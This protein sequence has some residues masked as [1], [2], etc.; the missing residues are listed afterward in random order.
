MAV[1]AKQWT[2]E[3]LDKQIL[4]DP[5]FHK[6][7][8][9]QQEQFALEVYKSAGY[10]PKPS[11]ESPPPQY[12][13]QKKA[14][15]PPNE[16]DTFLKQA[17]LPT[18]GAAGGNI[19]GTA[20]G[21]P[22]G[23]MIGEAAGSG[24]GEYANQKLG[25]SPES[26]LSIGLSTITPP[27][28]R[29]GAAALQHSPRLLPGASAALQEQAAQEARA[30]PSKAISVPTPSSELFSKLQ[31]MEKSHTVKVPF[32]RTLKAVKQLKA[33]ELGS[34]KGTQDVP[35]IQRLSDMEE[36]LQSGGLTFDEFDKTI[37]NLGRKISST[38]DATLKGSF[39]TIYRSLLEDVER[40]PAPAGV[41]L[42]L[43]RQA[44]KMYRK[45]MARTEF[46]NVIESQGIRKTGEF[47]D[48]VNPNAIA[49]WMKS[50]KQDYW[51]KSLDPGEYQQIESTLKDWATIPKNPVQRGQ[52]IG[53]G[54]KI[55]MVGAG[56]AIGGYAGGNMGAAFGMLAADKGSEYIA[57]ALTSTT[58]RNVLIKILRA[59]GGRFGQ[60]QAGLLGAFLAGGFGDVVAGSAGETPEAMQAPSRFVPKGLGERPRP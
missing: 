60:E 29:A 17:P 9:P 45:E 35:L 1:L 19:L 46:A 47:L 36:G 11:I 26:K 49:N 23:G 32:A 57:Q 15:A 3:E 41:P 28:F 58:G 2:V 51:R 14:A 44:R 10:E 5:D 8:P 59:S 22:V 31:P 4:A 33:E 18:L 43:W 48:Q 54:R 55:G 56:G 25:L 16:L 20:M 21:G 42:D 6:M 50:P 27:L 7:T 24:L 39:K 13:V 12:G 38:D 34:L 30:L 40:I 37:R 53:S 52:P